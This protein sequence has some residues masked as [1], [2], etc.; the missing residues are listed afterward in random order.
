MRRPLFQLHLST[1]IVL[2]FVAAALLW[3]NMRPR[4]ETSVVFRPHREPGWWEYTVLLGPLYGWPWPCG[5][6]S[7]EL[8]IA[9]QPTE[10]ETKE[11]P[12]VL[13]KQL[14]HRVV[15][16]R[17]PSL[18]QRVRFVPDGERPGHEQELIRSNAWPRLLSASR[19]ALDIL[20][21]L[22][23]LIAAAVFLEWRICRR[24]RPRAVTLNPNP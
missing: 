13:G 9:F 15:A 3:A 22:A 20:V 8:R 19:L 17:A 4:T 12:L 10:D 16:Q 11:L 7:G 2:M 23:I 18:W 5:G 21:A 6:D 24:Q 14:D 1:A